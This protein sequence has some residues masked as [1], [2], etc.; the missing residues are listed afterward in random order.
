MAAPDN[1]VVTQIDKLA[2]NPELVKHK[3]ILDEIRLEVKYLLLDLEATRRENQY[4]RRMLEQ[5]YE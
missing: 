4:L 5:E 3:G 2:T 1:I